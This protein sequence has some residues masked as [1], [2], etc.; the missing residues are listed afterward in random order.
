MNVGT[1]V[2]NQC[3]ANS[4]AAQS[5]LY[6]SYATMVMG[7]CRRYCTTRDEDDVF[8]DTFVKVFQSIHQFNGEGSIEGWIRRIAVNTCLTQ[9]R[10]NKIAV[11]LDDVPESAKSLHNFETPLDKLS[12]DALVAAIDTLPTGCK[13]VFNLYIV[14]GYSHK[15]I[16]AMMDI[17]EGTSKSQLHHAK[18]LLKK[19]FLKIDISKYA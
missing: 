9:L 8:Q 19:I 12:T 7:V 11:T 16:S 18:E 13:T 5:V 2:I 15:E 3:K 14:E 4:P 1:D 10:K 6:K 17:S